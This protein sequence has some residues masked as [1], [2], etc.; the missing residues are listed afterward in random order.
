[1]SDEELPINDAQTHHG[2]ESLR[3]PGGTTDDVQYEAKEAL[4]RYNAENPEQRDPDEPIGPASEGSAVTIRLEIEGAATPVLLNLNGDTVIGRRDP[5]SELSPELDMTPY[6]GY[7]MGISRRHAIIRA[8]GARLSVIDLGS[9][10]GSF[11]NGYRLKPHQ[12]VPLR[13]SD[14]LRLGK[15]IMRLYFVGM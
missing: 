15:I 2:Q 13:D 10:N 8:Q 4:E 9:R 5:T 7:Q 3:Q 14:E 12:A 1:M 11:L 6:D